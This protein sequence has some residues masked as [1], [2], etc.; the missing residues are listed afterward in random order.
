MSKTLVFTEF[1]GP[2]TQQLIDREVPVPE[3]SQVVIEVK[4]A[5]VNPADW[6]IRAGQMGDHWKLP[7]PMGREASGIVT[8]VGSDV[9]DFAVGD[10]VL[11]L[12]AKGHGTFAEHTVLN[13]KQTVAKPE[14]L[15]FANAAALP[16][17]GGT[18]YDVTHQ[19]ELEIG[20]TMV[21]LGAG[22]GVGLMAA[23]IGKVHQFNVIGVAS[24]S[25]QELVEATGATF[26][27]S[28]DGAADRVRGVASDGAD[29]LIDLVGGQPLRDI[30]SVAKDPSVIISTADPATA[31]ELGGA[32]VERTNEGLEKITGVAEYGLVDPNVVQRF[33][34][35]EVQQAIAVVEEGHAAGKVIIEP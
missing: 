30:A 20:Q 24:A 28:G 6:K 33:S 15:S 2:E 10:E 7:A 16:V 26:V 31:E 22:G 1:G 23:Q 34:L 4:A 21:I 25:K 9:E 18:A 14:E 8:A 13:G 27:E 32:G 35:D 3:A 12:A 5:G 11:G 29:L 17:A 19:I